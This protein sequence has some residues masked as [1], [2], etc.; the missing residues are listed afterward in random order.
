MYWESLPGW[1][2]TLY[3][4]F[5]AITFAS[6][7]FSISRKFFKKIAI[8]AIFF[9]ITVPIVSI[10][11]SIGREEGLNEYEYF[12]KELEHGTFWSIYVIIGYMFIL[13]WW[14]LLIFNK[15][16]YKSNNS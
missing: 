14:F 15:K 12:I 7:I 5:L 8:I 9:A 3:F 6:A 2:W 4:S 11:N 10:F 13:V 1:V 16:L